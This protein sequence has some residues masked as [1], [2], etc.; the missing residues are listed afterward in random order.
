MGFNKTSPISYS[1][2]QVK[3]RIHTSQH[4]PFILFD[5]MPLETLNYNIIGVQAIQEH[6]LPFL[7]AQPHEPLKLHYNDEEVYSLRQIIRNIRQVPSFETAANATKAQSPRPERSQSNPN[8]LSHDEA[9]R[10]Y[11]DIPMP[12]APP[13]PPPKPLIDIT[14]F[15]HLRKILP[16]LSMEHKNLREANRLPHEFFIKLKP[17]AKPYISSTY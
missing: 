2:G 14:W 4:S 13:P 8:L 10:L 12:H 1:S 7:L 16:R 15:Q 3:I 17:G 5:V 11:F 9:S 6:F